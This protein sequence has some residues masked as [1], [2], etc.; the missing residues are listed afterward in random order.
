VSPSLDV[1]RYPIDIQEASEKQIA[2]PVEIE[3]KVGQ[4]YE[5]PSSLR[6]NRVVQ[7]VLAIN[8]LIGFGAG[9]IIPL[10]TYYWGYIFKLSDEAIIGITVLGYIGMAAGSLVTP[11]V[12]RHATKYGGRVGT[13]VAFQSASIVFAGYLAIVPFQMNLSL[14]VIA[15]IAR[16]DF[17]NII[18]PLTSALLMDH[19]PANRRGL[20][21]SLVNIAFSVP[22]GIS[23]SFTSMI[24]IAVPAPYGYTYS[25]SFMVSLYL[26]GSV[27]YATTR[28]ADRLVRLSQHG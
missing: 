12:A 9:F 4:S 7:K 22:N 6:R 3:S 28:K 18:S 21:N 1:G 23:P 24:L 10:F 27:I 14:A 11:W 25:I 2:L 13:I 26:V 15:Y 20:V 5:V 19:S 8:L 17:M 16:T